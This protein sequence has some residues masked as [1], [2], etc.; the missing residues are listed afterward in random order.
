MWKAL[1]GCKARADWNLL[2]GGP[3]RGDFVFRFLP[4]YG[5]WNALKWG[6]FHSVSAFCNAGFDIFGV[7]TAGRQPDSVSDGPGGL[8]DADGFDCDRRPGLFVWEDVFRA[9]RA[10]SI[11]HL[12][13]YTKLVLVCTGVLIVAGT[14]VI[15]ALEWDNAD[16]LGSMTVPQKLLAGAFSP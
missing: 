3:G 4:D 7:F 5:L 15:C 9:I 1:S 6:V 14:G 13:V 16:T 10:H 11:R 12:S 2:L 8:L